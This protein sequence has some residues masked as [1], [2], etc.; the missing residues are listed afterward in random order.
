MDAFAGGADQFDD[1]TM[2]CVRLNPLENGAVLTVEPSMESVAQVSGFLEAQLEKMEVPIKTANRLMSATDESYS[3]IVR[4]S[5]AKSAQ[6]RCAAEKGRLTLT[7]RDDGKPYNPL[8][9]EEPDIAASA[10]E[11]EIGGL[12]IFMV[13]KLMDSVDY[14]YKDGHNVLTLTLAAEETEP[15]SS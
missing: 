6:V 1:I 8:E 10:E 13:R 4:Y 3:N 12:G 15:Q 9:A 14:M 5:G 11:R 2:L 7:F